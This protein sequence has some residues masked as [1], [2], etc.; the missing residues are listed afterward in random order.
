MSHKT[1]G[2]KI[3]HNNGI[4][5]T[6]IT[7]KSNKFSLFTILRLVDKEAMW[8]WTKAIIYLNYSLSLYLYI[9]KLVNF[10]LIGIRWDPLQRGRSL[11]GHTAPRVDVSII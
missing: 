7:N 3:W 2:I 11:K 4:T 10:W 1:A 5:N 6:S 9:I 8:D